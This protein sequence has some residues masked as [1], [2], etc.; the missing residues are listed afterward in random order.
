MLNKHEEKLGRP[1]EKYR[2]LEIPG[3]KEAVIHARANTALGESLPLGFGRGHFQTYTAD[4]PLF[5]KHVG[6]WYWAPRVHGNPEKGVV[7]GHYKMAA[8]PPEGIGRQQPSPIRQS[9][10]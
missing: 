10:K 8:Q 1:L 5:G 2:V 6:R 7:S 9:P 4:A 3:L